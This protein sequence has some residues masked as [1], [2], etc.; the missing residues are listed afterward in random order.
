MEEGK[1]LT[2]IY[3]HE[4]PGLYAAGDVKMIPDFI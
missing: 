4:L 1:G 2:W 3:G